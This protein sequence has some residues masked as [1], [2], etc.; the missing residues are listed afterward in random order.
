MDIHVSEKK[1]KRQKIHARVALT[2]LYNPRQGPV[3]KIVVVLAKAILDGNEVRHQQRQRRQGRQ[4]DEN[5]INEKLSG[6]PPRSQPKGNGKSHNDEHQHS[7]RS[8][9]AA[10][11][12][13]IKVAD[14]SLN[15]A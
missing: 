7:H 4:V 11:I 14:G 12:G 13:V 9:F 15:A 8:L 6:Q 5:I 3:G 1:K 2:G 10:L